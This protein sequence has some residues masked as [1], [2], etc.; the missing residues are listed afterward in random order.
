MRQWEIAEFLATTECSAWVALDDEELV[1]GAEQARHRD[2]FRGRVS[3][4]ESSLGLQDVHVAEA[5]QTLG[6]VD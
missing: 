5:I 4:I 6:A 3:T 1:E 2:L